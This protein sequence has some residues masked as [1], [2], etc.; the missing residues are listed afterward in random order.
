MQRGK[1]VFFVTNSASKHR[2]TFL[3]KFHRLGFASV[4]LDQIYSSAFATAMYMKRTASDCHTCYTIGADGIA[5]ELKDAGFEVIG[6]TEFSKE[7]FTKE[8]TY[9]ENLRLNP[10]VGAV[11][12]GRYMMPPPLINSKNLIATNQPILPGFNMQV[13]YATLALGTRYLLEQDTVFLATNGDRVG[14]HG[15]Q[16]GKV[17]NL[18]AGGMAVAALEYASGRKSTLIGKPE[19]HLLDTIFNLNSHLD[20]DRAM[21][22]GDRLDTDIEFGLRGK[23]L[24]SPYD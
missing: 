24:F 19:Q 14:K 13:N 16:S 9:V 23:K 8:D 2:N 10:N 1:H 6:G 22:I 20:R 3:A 7:M 12:T 15:E 11:I 4:T 5:E 21:M 18:P 17:V